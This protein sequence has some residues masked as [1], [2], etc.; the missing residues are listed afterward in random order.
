MGGR[1]VDFAWR[2]QL[3]TAIGDR[4]R[5]ARL[6]ASMSERQLAERLGCA[7]S[8]LQNIEQGALSCPV[9][10]LVQLAH[11]FDCT[12]DDFIPVDGKV[13]LRDGVEPKE[14]LDG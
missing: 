4:V 1:Q 11:L 6:K 12:I 14:A 8:T 9:Y 10:V 2:R 5:A 3:Y 7:T 13:M